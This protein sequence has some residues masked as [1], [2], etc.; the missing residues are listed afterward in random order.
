MSYPVAKADLRAGREWQR[1]KSSALPEAVNLVPFASGFGHD[2]T[3]NRSEGSP[4]AAAD[5]P[6]TLGLHWWSG[7][8]IRCSHFIGAVRLGEGADAPCLCVRPKVERLD[9]AAVFA[10]VLAAP[11]TQTGVEFHRLFGCDPAQAPIEGVE[12]PQ[13]TL[14][15]VTA[16]LYCLAQFARRHL[17][18]DF[19]RVEENLVGRVRGR[20]RIADQV[21]ENLVRARADRMVCEFTVLGRDTLENRILKAALAAGLRWLHQQPRSVLPDAVWHWGALGRAALTAVPVQRIAPREWKTARRY[22]AMRH[23]AEPLALAE[24]VLTR[25]HLDPSGCATKGQHTLPFFLDGNRLFEAWVGVCLGYADCQPEAQ[26]ER[27]FS[28][29]NEYRWKLRPDFLVSLEDKV[30][31]AIVDAKYKP[32][33]PGNGDLTRDVRKKNAK[34][35]KER[36]GAGRRRVSEGWAANRVLVGPTPG[37]G[38]QGQGTR[39]PSGSI[40]SVASI[41]AVEYIGS[42]GAL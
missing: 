4:P 13:L 34:N 22:G 36:R 39:W 23:Y 33:K 17:R 15:E 16:Y 38:C 27:C 6:R 24:L 25:L 18:E 5:N 20:V 31:R 29:P 3:W 14:L 32:G 1:W 37:A 11:P 2:H 30:G 10:A 28:L 40:S 9:L 8:G 12:L 19:R 26:R 7:G 21:R 41:R 42:P 35:A